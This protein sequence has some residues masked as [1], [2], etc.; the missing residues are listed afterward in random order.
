MKKTS[1]IKVISVLIAL[2]SLNAC[3]KS[4]F[5]NLSSFIY[6][7]NFETDFYMLS[8]SDFYYTEGETTC[9][10]T[11]YFNEVEGE[12]VS[13]K[14]I[15]NFDYEIQECYITICKIDN[16]GETMSIS[17]N[18]QTLFKNIVCKTIE[19]FTLKDNDF[20]NTIA[21]EFMLDLPSTYTDEGELNKQDGNFYYL[22]LSNSITNEFVIYNTWLSPQEEYEKPVSSPAYDS[23]TDIR[24]GTVALR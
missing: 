17:Q 3:V 1:L 2:I 5:V 13:L 22:Y 14:I 9:T 6:N 23:T 7:F 18:T 11:V 21:A 16:D 10:Y 24:E 8:F 20:A 15:E 19:A 4:E 12:Y